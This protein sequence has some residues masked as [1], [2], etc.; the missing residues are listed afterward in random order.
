MILHRRTAVAG[1]RLNRSSTDGG[2]DRLLRS[3]TSA[4]R[5]RRLDSARVETCETEVRPRPRARSAPSRTRLGQRQRPR[6]SNSNIASRFLP[7]ASP[8]VFQWSRPDD[9]EMEHQP[10]TAVEADRICF[11][12]RRTSVRFRFCR[13][14]AADSPREAETGPSQAIRR[15]RVTDDARLPGLLI[16]RYVQAVPALSFRERISHPRLTTIAQV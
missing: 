7:R 8:A 11:P 2:M 14:K 4:A 15:S 3:A 12:S 9:F 13:P 1:C 16:Y 10:E 6:L 5:P